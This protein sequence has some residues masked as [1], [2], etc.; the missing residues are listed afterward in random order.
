MDS[1]VA[2]IKK[3]HSVR[4]YSEREIENDTLQ[5]IRRYLNGNREGPFGSEVRFDI[6]D[7]TQ[8]EQADLKDL[9]TYGM[10][11]GARVYVAGVVKKSER[12][13]E[14]F[15]YC[16]E[17]NILM[18]T[19]LGLATCW[20]GGSL[21]RS[22]FTSKMNAAADELLPGITPIGYAEGKKTFTETM[23]AISS[24]VSGNKSRRKKSEELFFDKSLDT[25]L[26][27]KACGQYA[28]ALEA[29][30][31]APSAMNGQPWRI[32][33]DTS[34]HLFLNEKDTRFNH[35]GDV[36]FQRMDIGI[37]MCH[38][39]LAANELGLKGIWKIERPPIEAGDLKYIVSW[40]EEGAV[41]S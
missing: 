25:P 8:Y 40:T 36:K 10:I 32:I 9:G 1:V 39:E 21:N 4:Y 31:A 23:T 18:L 37:A 30:R 14:D 19:G 41:T 20:I 5:T 3:R 17:K 34:Y 13:M 6:V 33:K 29:L 16:M 2:I 28:T 24:A 26:V 11:K 15:G 12:A 7:A 22:V 35:Y 27:L 38:F